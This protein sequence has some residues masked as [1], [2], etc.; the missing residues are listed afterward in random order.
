MKVGESYG[1]LGI[2]ILIS[3]HPGYTARSLFFVKEINVLLKPPF[4]IGIMAGKR[5]DKIGE[6]I[7]LRKKEDITKHHDIFF[8]VREIIN[9]FSRNMTK[10][11]SSEWIVCV[12][13]STVVLYNKYSSI[14]V[15]I[16]IKSHT[17][18]NEYN[19]TA[20]CEKN[21]LQ[22]QNCE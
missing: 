15:S 7:H 19:S 6:C 8:W 11:F 3:L 20:C 22:D 9:R 5:F 1:W 18:V 16:K 13:T 17:I 21:Y 4:I 12:D 10:C 2:L 14:W